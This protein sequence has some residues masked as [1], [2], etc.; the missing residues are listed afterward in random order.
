MAAPQISDG[1]LVSPRFPW[2]RAQ[3]DPDDYASPTQ[4]VTGG[5]WLVV[6]RRGDYA[7]CLIDG[8]LQWWLHVSVLTLVSPKADAEPS[9]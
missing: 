6:K 3:R 2:V 5:P 4:S 7:N 8:G 9:G 1:V